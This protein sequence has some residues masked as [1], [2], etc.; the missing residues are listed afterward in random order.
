MSATEEYEDIDATDSENESGTEMGSFADVTSVT[1]EEVN[2][3]VDMLVTPSEST[4]NSVSPSYSFYAWTAKTSAESTTK[5]TQKFSVEN[6]GYCYQANDDVALRP[7]ND[8]YTIVKD[9]DNKFYRAI[10]QYT[11]KEKSKNYN[12]FVLVNADSDEAA[13]NFLYTSAK[14][15]APITTKKLAKYERAEKLPE[16]MKL[17]E[18]FGTKKGLVYSSVHRDFV[19]KRVASKKRQLQK[20]EHE[21]KKRRK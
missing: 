1:D 12:V 10:M 13:V 19:N 18:I 11:D 6:E 15:N 9:A 16:K 14:K 17:D 21:M 7:K 3:L 8:E 4:T 5:C 2:E 20:R